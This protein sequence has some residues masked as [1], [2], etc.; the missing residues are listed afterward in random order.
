MSN[1]QASREPAGRSPSVERVETKLEVVVL[2]VSDVDRAKRFYGGLGWRL[3]ADFANGPD[4]RVVQLTPP[5]SPCSIIFGTGVTAA[6]PGSVQKIMLVVDDIDAART[7]L[8]GR[9]AD[10]SAVFHEE[11]GSFTTPARRGAFRAWTRSVARTE[12]GLRSEIR[13]AM[14]GCSKRSRRACPD[15]YGQRLRSVR[16]TCSGGPL[17]SSAVPRA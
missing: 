4:F 12:A 9:G 3:D 14:A 10:V 6:A 8:L 11:V 17:S 13:M 15:A 7:E 1:P 2:P 16:R 5:G